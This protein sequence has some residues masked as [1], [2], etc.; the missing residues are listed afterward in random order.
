[1]KSLREVHRALFEL[2]IVGDLHHLRLIAADLTGVS[3]LASLIV[4]DCAATRLILVI[5]LGY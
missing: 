4:I 5:S 3:E 2:M 1:M